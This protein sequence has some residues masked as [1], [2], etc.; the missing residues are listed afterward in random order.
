MR[1]VDVAVVGGGLA[2][3]LAAA[4]LGRAGA[5]TVVIDPHEVYPPDF[6]CE[7]L[8][9]SQVGLLSKTGLHDA[10]RRAATMSDDV[11]IAR[12]G[13][14]IEKRRA[15]QYDLLYD[16]LVNTIQIGRASCRERVCQYV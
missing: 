3:S 10:V 13:N 7:K 1:Q 4:M 14:R 16:T 6:R 5:K 11:W 2:G 12:R 15:G 8:D 9:R